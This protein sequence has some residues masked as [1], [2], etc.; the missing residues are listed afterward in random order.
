MQ[1][2]LPVLDMHCAASS[3]SESA[4]QSPRRRRSHVQRQ[5]LLQPSLFLPSFDKHRTSTVHRW[6]AG[7]KGRR[8]APWLSATPQAR[9]ARTSHLSARSPLLP[10]HPYLHHGTCHSQECA[11]GAF[12]TQFSRRTVSQSSSERTMWCL[13][14]F[15]TAEKIENRSQRW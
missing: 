8:G 14:K 10:E 1:Q 11:N 15:G 7:Q 4:T 13:T 5:R 12:R 9:S 6:T 2:D 3:M